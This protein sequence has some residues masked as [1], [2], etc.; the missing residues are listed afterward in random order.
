MKNKIAL[1]L[2]AYLAA[3]LLVFALISGLL[4]KAL[5]TKAVLDNKKAEMLSRA[6]GLSRT[7]QGMLEGPAQGGGPKMGSQGMNYTAFV[8]A[9]TQA[10]DDI[11]VLNEN[12]EFLSG[13]MMRGRTLTYTNLPPD[14]ERLVRAVFEGETPYSEGF[15]DLLGAPTL[16]LGVPIYAG[17][18]VKGALLLHD[19]VSGITEA[20]KQGQNILLMS[21]A[22]ALL[23]AA[24]PTIL[25]SFTLTK[26]IRR[27]QTVAGQL[28]RGDYEAR[29]GV[30]QADEIGE[31]AGSVD[32]LAR[33]LKDAREQK[34][35]EEQRRNDFLASISHELRTP[36]T[37]LST[38]LE[39]L[40][41][42][43]VTKPEDVKEY[44]EQMLK[45]TRGLSVLVNDLMDLAR[46]Q[47]ADFPIERKELVLNDVL[48]DALHSAERLADK[49]GIRIIEDVPSAPL[50]YTGDYARLR[51]MLLIPLDNAIK[52]SKP[53]SD[54]RVKMDKEG[55][56][57]TDDGPGIKPEE[58]PHLFDRFRKARTEENREGSGLGLAIA[59][60][61]ARRHNIRL[62]LESEE[63]KGTR[64]RFLL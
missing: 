9:L 60:E 41:D 64:V 16:T 17:S 24:M 14:A 13:G 37:V 42:G 55:I 6:Q 7:L 35:L 62:I 4:F 54:I 23:L 57:I 46:L 21:G 47:N 51:Q 31:L 10:D 12:L 45:D 56:T 22:I 58:L 48:K 61:I 34:E 19:A 44:H 25:L 3:A 63:D 36:V 39:A 26:P 30:H 49:K 2:L 11:W 52:F 38:S 50:P 29:T 8:R 20:T 18:E 27:I 53:G 1:K 43:V 32:T 40:N 15:S 59:R 5:F 33:D 28:S